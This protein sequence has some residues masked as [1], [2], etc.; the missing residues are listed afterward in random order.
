MRML[1]STKWR[2]HSICKH[3]VSPQ[4][5][6]RALHTPPCLCSTWVWK[7]SQPPW[8]RSSSRSDTLNPLPSQITP[9]R[10]M[11]ELC[12]MHL[13]G[14]RPTSLSFTHK[15]LLFLNHFP[16]VVLA[17]YVSHRLW[18]VSI[19]SVCCVN[20]KIKINSRFVCVLVYVL[21]TYRQDSEYMFRACK[22]T[23]Q[24]KRKSKCMLLAIAH[25]VG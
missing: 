20:G 23:F 9:H 16:H 5:V 8:D 2:S 18:T 12:V 17:T 10:M 7:W 21:A 22:T 4:T 19:V 13:Q 15:L 6:N 25:L 14:M 11:N 3:W 24:S 1:H